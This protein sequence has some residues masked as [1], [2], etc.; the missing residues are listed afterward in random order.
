MISEIYTCWRLL[1]SLTERGP[2]GRTGRHR[3][4]AAISRLCVRSADGPLRTAR[5]PPLFDR[6]STR[7]RRVVTAALAPRSDVGPYTYTRRVRRKHVRFGR[8][9][10]PGDLCHWWRRLR[11]DHARLPR[12]RRRR[13]RDNRGRPSG[14]VS[15]A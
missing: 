2:N 10:L 4:A 13:R 15:F 11:G 12:R 8:R 6:F 14:T 5:K 7:H 1:S 3:N 9:D